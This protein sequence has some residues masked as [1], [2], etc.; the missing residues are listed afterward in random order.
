MNYLK[1]LCILTA[2]L[3]LTSCASTNV[4]ST[5]NPSEAWL[6]LCPRVEGQA[7]TNFGETQTQLNDLLDLYTE[8]RVRHN[9]W[10]EFERKRIK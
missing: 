9:A 2:S 7:P 8:C 4:N 10:V 3:I 6:V 5:S 1:T